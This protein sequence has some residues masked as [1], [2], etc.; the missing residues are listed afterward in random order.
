[1]KIRP[2]FPLACAMLMA[3]A[4]TSGARAAPCDS[5]GPEDRLPALT[6]EKLSA[7]ARLLCNT[8][9]AVLHSGIA[10]EPVS[11]THLTLPT[12]LLV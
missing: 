4:L 5:M 1:M 6:N 3:A 2:L 10:H 9:F 7:Q 11:Y 12:I 8:A